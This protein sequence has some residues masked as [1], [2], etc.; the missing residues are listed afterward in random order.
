MEGI[1]N[2]VTSAFKSFG[3]TVSNDA[4][5]MWDK[6]KKTSSSAY[7]S[8]VGT[9]TNTNSNTNSNINSNTSTY[10]N[11]TSTNPTT[12][13]NN[14]V[15]GGKRRRRRYSRSIKKGG[16]HDYNPLHGLASHAAS[17]SGETAKVNTIVGGR[18]TKRSRKTKHSRS[19]C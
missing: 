16:Y 7:K 13:T 12:N 10:P 19:R 14:P 11:T 15:S 8:T 17:F 4:S 3:N 5:N 2:N 18:K 6:V 1:L 9:G